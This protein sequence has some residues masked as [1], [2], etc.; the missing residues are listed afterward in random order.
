M[1]VKG[2][3]DLVR[4]MRTGA[5]LNINST[6]L[7]NEKRKLKIKKQQEVEY[8]QLKQDVADIKSLLYQLLEKN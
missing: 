1:K 8:E 3:P 4:D 5:L 7:N 6:Y 2:Q